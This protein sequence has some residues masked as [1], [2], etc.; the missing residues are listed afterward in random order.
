MRLFQADD[1]FHI[2]NVNLDPW[3]FTFSTEFYMEYMSR[4][5]DLFFCED[6]PNGEIAGF[7][8]AKVEGDKAPEKMDWHGHVSVLTIANEY[9][10]LGYSRRFMEFMEAVS[11][12]V[13]AI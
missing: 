12:K 9:R 8:I 2:S 6:T 13:Y 5:P 1:F 3:T 4:W 10:R 7:G 11:E